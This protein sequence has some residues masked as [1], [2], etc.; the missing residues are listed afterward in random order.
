VKTQSKVINGTFEKAL[1]KSL[2]KVFVVLKRTVGLRLAAVLVKQ[3]L[4]RQIRR[5]F[6]LVA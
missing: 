3:K 2:S 6:G 1:I 4:N 5:G